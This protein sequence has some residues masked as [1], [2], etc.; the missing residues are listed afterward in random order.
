[1]KLGQLLEGLP[2]YDLDGDIG[3]EIK[4]LCYDSRRIQQGDLFVAIK[5]Y[6]QNGHEFLNDAVR[7][8]AVALVAEEFRESYGEASKILVPDSRECPFKTCCSIL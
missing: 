4:R 1:M 5:G 2:D 8:G 3:L 6:S 7:K